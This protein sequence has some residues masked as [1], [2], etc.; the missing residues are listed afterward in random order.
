MITAAV[1]GRFVGPVEPPGTA[2][3]LPAAAP[4]GDACPEASSLRRGQAGGLEGPRRQRGHGGVFHVFVRSK[5]FGAWDTGWGMINVGVPSTTAT[6]H[7]IVQDGCGIILLE[8]LRA[9]STRRRLNISQSLFFFFLVAVHGPQLFLKLCTVVLASRRRPA[10]PMPILTLHPKEIQQRCPSWVFVPKR[11]HGTAVTGLKNR[12]NELF[13][14]LFFLV[15]GVWCLTGRPPA[16]LVFPRCRGGRRG[17]RGG[18]PDPGGS[19]HRRQR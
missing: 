6:M 11:Y 14:Y 12:W 17:G 18:R 7:E 10:R 16:Q 9:P 5:P 15:A 3:L 2:A 19:R 4:G 8:L 1:Q 13:I